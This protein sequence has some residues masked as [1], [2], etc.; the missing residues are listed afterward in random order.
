M[1]LGAAV[2]ILWHFVAATLPAAKGLRVTG[3]TQ[4]ARVDSVSKA[5]APLKRI[6]A[7]IIVLIIQQLRL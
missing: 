1:K 7:S 6:L 5:S 3:K 4:R 2:S